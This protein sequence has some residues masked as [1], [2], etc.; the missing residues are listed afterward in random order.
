[1][2]N[3][4][5]HRSFSHLLEAYK[6]A[7]SKNIA[8]VLT[9]TIV[10][11]FLASCGPVTTGQASIVAPQFASTL[12]VVQFAPPLPGPAILDLRPMSMSIVGH[13]DCQIKGA[14]VC[15]ALVISRSSNQNTL[16]W[17]A[18]TNVPGH[19]VFRPSRGVLAPGRSVLVTII[20]P[21]T[22]CT[23]GLFFFRGQTN[24]HTI[25]WAC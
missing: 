14:F 16:H 10:L 19:I 18:F 6:G 7:R 15:R 25:A 3:L 21:F 1:M 24:T 22:A 8:I 2:C 20:V 23:H 11:S 5:S 4:R 9:L 12:D 13:L 17:F